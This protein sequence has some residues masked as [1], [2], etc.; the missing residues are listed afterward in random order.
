MTALHVASAPWAMC[1]IQAGCCISQQNIPGLTLTLDSMYLV[2][3]TKHW[4][5]LSVALLCQVVSPAPGTPA[6]PSAKAYT[7]CTHR[8]QHAAAGCMAAHN[9]LRAQAGLPALQS[10]HLAQH[11]C[12]GYPAWRPMHLASPPPSSPR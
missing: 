9:P 10:R 4:A 6:T 2:D 8:P 12:R 3:Q 7:A 11:V 1:M 5:Q